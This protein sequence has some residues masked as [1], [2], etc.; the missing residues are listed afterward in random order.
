VGMPKAGRH[1][2][3]IRQA[4]EAGPRRRCTSKRLQGSSSHRVSSVLR[5]WVMTLRYQSREKRAQAG[6]AVLMMTGKMS[7]K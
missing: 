7:K 2:Y 4:M 6:G 5:T 1:T 3:I